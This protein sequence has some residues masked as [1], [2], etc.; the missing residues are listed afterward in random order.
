MQAVGT[1]QR[2]PSSHGLLPALFLVLLALLMGVGITVVGPMAV[3]PIFGVLFFALVVARPEYGIALF[4]STFLITYPEALQGAGTLTINNVLG[5]LFVILLTY[6]VYRDH[7]WWFLR[8]RELQLLAFIYLVSTIANRFNGPDPRLMSVVGVLM[9]QADTSRTF[10][11]RSVFTV[12]FVNY[13]R[14]PGHVVMIYLL[15]VM[16]MIGSA[17]VGVHSVLHGGALHGYRAVG[18]VISSAANPNRLAMFSIMPI[19]GLWFLMRSLRVPVLSILVLPVIAVLALAVFMTGSRSGLLGLGVCVALLI[20][21]ERLNLN[22]LLALGL[23]GVLVLV[24]ALQL[25]PEKT[26]ERITNLPFTQSG[27][28]GLGV[29]SLERREYGWKIAFSMFKQHPFIGVGIGN[30]EL[31]RYLNDP[32]RSVGAPHSSYALALVEGGLLSLIAFLWLL[33][34]TW[35]NL[36]SVKQYVSDPASPLAS[37]KWV[38]DSA[39]VNVLVLVFFSL[40]ADLF[41]LVI[42]FWLVGLSIVIRRLAEQRVLEEAL[43]AE[44]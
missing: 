3:L 35:R 43:Y 37:L 21:K 23:A 14:T 39:E 38:V 10:L 2:F 13:I 26:F 30:W 22:E 8:C 16:L 32:Q 33:W 31:A 18:G 12:F 44:P 7:D 20:T 6:K 19:A 36:R 5:G 42:L 34:R 27:E 17:V 41:Q 24:L 25:V 40:F 4:L 15:A 28:T 29:G 11:T 9:A 1:V